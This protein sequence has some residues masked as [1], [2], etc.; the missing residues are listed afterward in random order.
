MVFTQ[1]KNLCTQKTWTQTQLDVIPTLFTIAPNSEETTMSFERWMGHPNNE[2]VQ[3]SSVQS[4][5]GI[6]LQPHESQCTR[7][8]CPSPA[9]GIHSNSCPSSQWCH[10]AISSSVVPFSSC[11]QSLPASVF[12]NESTLSMRWPKYW[13][14]MEFHHSFQRTPRTDLLQNGLIESPCN[15]GDSQESSPPGYMKPV[16]HYKFINIDIMGVHEGEERKEK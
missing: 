14:F 16:G 5:S 11:P 12:S 10:S 1:V 15:P 13:S 8:P 3:F 6:W 4:L 2:I 7:P 9:P